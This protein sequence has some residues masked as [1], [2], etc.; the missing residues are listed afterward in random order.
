M[1]LMTIFGI[2]FKTARAG[3]S[4][5]PQAVI[6]KGRSRSQT[7]NGL[8]EKV[9]GVGES[10]VE[11]LR[12]TKEEGECEESAIEESSLKLK[13]I[14]HYSHDDDPVKMIRR[15]FVGLV[16]RKQQ[17][18][19]R[20]LS[21]NPNARNLSSNPVSSARHLSSNPNPQHLV[22][23]PSPIKT[24]P[25]PRTTTKPISKPSYAPQAGF[26]SQPH[27]ISSAPTPPQKRRRFDRFL[28]LTPRFSKGVGKIQLGHNEKLVMK[29]FKKDRADLA[30]IQR[31]F[32]WHY[33]A[34][35]CFLSTTLSSDLFL[36]DIVCYSVMLATL[37]RVNRHFHAKKTGTVTEIVLVEGGKVRVQQL[38]WWGGSRTSY[39][40]VE[41]CSLGSMETLGRVTGKTVPVEWDRAKMFISER[42]WVKYREEELART[43]ERWFAPYPIDRITTTEVMYPERR[44]ADILQEKKEEEL[45]GSSQ[46]EREDVL[47]IEKSEEKG[48]VKYVKT[49]N[50][51]C[52]SNNLSPQSVSSV[53]EWQEHIKEQEHGDS[54]VQADLLGKRAVWGVPA[55]KLEDGSIKLCNS[56]EELYGTGWVEP[57]PLGTELIIGMN[58]IQVL[59]MDPVNPS[60]HCSVCDVK[61]HHTD[62]Q[63]LLGRE[64]TINVIW[65]WE[66][67]TADRI[68]K[69]LDF[70]K[71]TTR[72]KAAAEMEM[73]IKKVFHLE[74]DKLTERQAD[75]YQLLIS[76]KK[77]TDLSSAGRKVR[78]EEDFMPADVRMEYELYAMM[79]ELSAGKYSLNPNVNDPNHHI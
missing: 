9:E 44:A 79:D 15:P 52:Y 33:L 34:I 77:P 2:P 27:N 75:V 35:G 54:V 58:C 19:F 22:P 31:V 25:P 41:E 53:A 8:V 69:G 12:L 62:R 30:A 42:E 32:T 70:P 26:I 73:M 29:M 18:C 51:D 76:K 47:G 68:A 57:N 20:Y 1:N 5:N 50:Q 74:K 6:L 72:Q 65:N 48:G 61:F 63:H 60:Y 37:F 49:K 55:V 64:H 17:L 3:L 21:S 23:D 36:Y 78:Q 28:E 45:L 16:I 67:A 59:K 11:K 10:L 38:T 7:F 43:H 14:S 46:E 39:H 4:T 71:P 40:P 66:P 24:T 56:F 13:S